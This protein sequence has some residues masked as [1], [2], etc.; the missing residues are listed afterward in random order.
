MGRAFKVSYNRPVNATQ[1]THGDF[2]SYEYPIVRFLEANGYDVSYIAS[3]DTDRARSIGRQNRQLLGGSGHR[4][5]AVYGT[6]GAFAPRCRVEQDDAHPRP[7]RSALLYPCEGRDQP[8]ATRRSP[9]RV[10]FQ[11]PH[12][13]L[14]SRR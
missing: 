1:S 14:R 5:V 9:S 4:D 13:E 2:I 3:A 10:A 12:V 7:R 6:L 8:L 11:L